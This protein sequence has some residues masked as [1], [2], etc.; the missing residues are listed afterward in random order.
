MNRPGHL[1]FALLILSPL[2]KFTDVNF[3][4]ITTLF[5]LT[6]D[7]DMILKIRHRAYTHNVTFGALLALASA[8]ITV[9]VLKAPTK[10]F[11][12][13]L[14]AFTGVAIHIIADLLTIQKFAPLYP[15]SNKKMSLRLLRSNNAVVNA[16]L[17]V[18]GVF[19]F[20]FFLTRC[21]AQVW[22][23]NPD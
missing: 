3:V 1:G 15:F 5:S 12:Y 23:F 18:L 2:M 8:L 4:V 7:V 16:S 17:F 10:G 22:F 19:S 14:A 6:P 11:E 20:I 9:F 13:A 21:F